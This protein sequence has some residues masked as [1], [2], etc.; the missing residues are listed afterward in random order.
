MKLSEQEQRQRLAAHFAMPGPGETEP[1]AAELGDPKG[2]DGWAPCVR[3]LQIGEAP[4]EVWAMLTAEQQLELAEADPDGRE[5]LPAPPE[6]PHP[7]DMGNS[8]RFAV[9]H[10]D[11]VRFDHT[12]GRWLV[13]DGRRWRCDADAEVA[14][15]ARET[16]R[17]MYA[18]AGKIEDADERKRLGRWAV[19]SESDHRIRSM[20]HMAES[21]AEIAIHHGRLDCDP[22][23]LTVLNGTLDLRTGELRPHD[24]EDLITRL[25][26]VEYDPDARLPLWDRFLA[27]A[28]D[29]DAELA[30]FLARCAGYSLTGDA[31]EEVLFFV[32]GPTCA[33]KSTFL[34][35]LKATMGDYA[36]TA[37][38]ET[39]LA[40]SWVGGPRPD[41]ARL[42]SARMAAS[43]EVAQGKRLAEGLVKLLTGGDT[44]TARFLYSR[45]FEFVPSFKLW[46]SANDA[47]SA[48][49]QDDALWRRI[50]TIPFDTT[51]A[52]PDPAVKAAL[53]DPSVAGPAIIA[54]A[55]RGCLAWQR[56]GLRVPERVRAATEAY[57]LSQDPLRDF[58]ADCC[59]LSANAWTSASDLRQAYE[60]WAKENGEKY[61]AAGK[62]WGDGLRTRGCEQS[63]EYVG[64]HQVRGWRGIGLLAG[65]NKTGKTDKTGFA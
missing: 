18:Q 54:W 42:A 35:A 8:S 63:R 51:V 49:H 16:V 29:G 38:F 59:V 34:E 48:P 26:P 52:E 12:G 14:R 28:T 11:E 9:Q 7:T 41:I 47:P 64:T 1:D 45:E 6:A 3:L 40:R 32:Y 2:W 23:L 15:M 5:P 36:T 43:V 25:A 39:F 60:A 17:T 19:S 20:M 56:E 27:D 53:R 62:S 65:A 37:D 55:V 57:R 24:P 22:W 58:V 46:L 33:G 44:V 21:E 4:D 30:D 31:S 61:L 10:G 50:L 13:W